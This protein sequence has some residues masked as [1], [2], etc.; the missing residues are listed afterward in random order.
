MR[1]ENQLRPAIAAPAIAADRREMGKRV[2]IDDKPPAAGKKPA[3][4][5][6]RSFA[7]PKT[8]PDDRH[9]GMR[10]FAAKVKHRRLG[11]QRS[12]ST[13]RLRRDD[14]TN[15]PRSGGS[16]SEA[17]DHGGVREAV[18]TADDRNGADG[19]LVRVTRPRT[20]AP[21][22]LLRR[23]HARVIIPKNAAQHIRR[24]KSA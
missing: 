23:F 6:P 22:Y 16:C 17:C 19:T 5:K 12:R 15:K 2:G 9:I 10:N 24:A 4:G 3:H 20:K 11:E 13:A 1:S 8:G 14:E 18:R 7:E 21:C